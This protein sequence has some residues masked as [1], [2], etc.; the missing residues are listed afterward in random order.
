MKSVCGTIECP[1][2]MS[3]W[4]GLGR[5]RVGEAEKGVWNEG[6]HLANTKWRLQCP[7]VLLHLSTC[8]VCGSTE[9]LTLST[10]EVYRRGLLSSCQMLPCETQNTV[11]LWYRGILVILTD[12]HRRRTLLDTWLQ[13]LGA[14]LIRKVFEIIDPE[15]LPPNRS[16]FGWYA[17]SQYITIHTNLMQK[18]RFSFLEIKIWS[19]W[20]WLMLWVEASKCINVKCSVRFRREQN[21]LNTSSIGHDRVEAQITE[22]LINSEPTNTWKYKYVYIYINMELN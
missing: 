12:Q 10:A 16:I 13:N 20:T 3:Y 5:G 1:F 2:G 8:I 17:N 7:S 21:I 22:F 11:R 9:V 6:G 14:V 15:L 4:V 19:L 18:T